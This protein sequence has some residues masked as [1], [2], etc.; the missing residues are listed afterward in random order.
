VMV[1]AMA[2]AV[3]VAVA[4]AAATAVTAVITMAAS[5][6]PASTTTIWAINNDRPG[7]A[8]SNRGRYTEG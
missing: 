7:I 3:A 5:S 4:V 8:V 2:V 6:L 1:M